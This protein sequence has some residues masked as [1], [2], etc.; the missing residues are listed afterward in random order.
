VSQW[1][2]TIESGR[3]SQVPPQSTAIATE[4]HCLDNAWDHCIS[5]VRYDRIE[6]RFSGTTSKD[7]RLPQ[8]CPVLTTHGI[9]VI[10]MVDEFRNGVWPAR[11]FLEDRQLPRRYCVCNALTTDVP[12]SGTI[13]SNRVELRRHHLEE[14]RMPRRCYIANKRAAMEGN[15]NR[16]KGD[17][18][19][20]V[21]DRRQR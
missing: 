15:E 21:I 20:Q 14:L 19:I 4:I 5:M 3:G 17:S 12:I 11:Y 9:S 7:K 18:F 6:S 10:S 2:A 8:R 1:Y 13:R 16:R